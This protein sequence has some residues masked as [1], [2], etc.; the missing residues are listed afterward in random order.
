MQSL[1]EATLNVLCVCSSVCW[2]SR[3]VRYIEPSF[4]ILLYMG[5]L[6]AEH[7]STGTA[8]PWQHQLLL[9]RAV[10]AFGAL[11]IF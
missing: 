11:D 5:G 10:R 3:P 4:I 1:D 8:A 6:Q 7:D 9:R 2:D